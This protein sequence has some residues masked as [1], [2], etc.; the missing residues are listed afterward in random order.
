MY[1]YLKAVKSYIDFDGRASREEYW[2]FT[3]FDFIFLFACIGLDALF[4]AG[5]ST[6]L[7][8]L[9]LVLPRLAVTVRRLHDIDKS[10]WYLLVVL[11]PIVGGIVL[12]VLMVLP[13]TKGYNSYGDEFS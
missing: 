8:T 6:L 12:L 10:A 4:T 1:W 13:G 11:V 5:F 3:L 9:G 7:Y 2:M